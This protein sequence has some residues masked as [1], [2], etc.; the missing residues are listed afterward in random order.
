MKKKYYAVKKGRQTG[1]FETWSEC[2]RQVIGFAGASFK[3][4]P[5]IEEAEA[6][7]SGAQS[8]SDSSNADIAKQLDHIDADTLVAF[9]DGSFSAAKKRYSF[10]A[11]LLHSE[12][13]TLLSAAFS[14]PDKIHARNV[15]GE[16]EGVKQAIDWAIAHSKSKILVYYDY[17]GIEK[18]ATGDW[19]AKQPLTQDYANFFAEKSQLIQ[20]AF[21]HVKAHSGIRYNEKA[22]M[23]AKQALEK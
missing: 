21:Q 22:D 16:I 13:E 14:D 4:F 11:V 3:S 23:L 8:A 6:F 19:Q 1:I 20:V 18:W 9:V 5:S 2:Q 10:G 7:L 17:E 15:A 12:G